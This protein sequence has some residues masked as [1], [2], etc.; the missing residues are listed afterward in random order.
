[1]TYC[2]CGNSY[3]TKRR[4][5]YYSLTCV[6]C[7]VKPVEFTKITFSVCKCGMILCNKPKTF[8]HCSA[9]EY[10]KVAF[11]KVCNI[12]I[13][14]HKGYCSRKCLKYS[15]RAREKKRVRDCTPKWA[16]KY[17][18]AKFHL[19]KNGNHV[20]HI[21]PINHPS[22]C[23]LNVLCNLQYLSPTENEFKSNKFDFT[24]ENK[25]WKLDLL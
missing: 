12:R 15:L 2:K 4:D 19:G 3:P 24:Y 22:V 16:N 13:P 23:G 21:I 9:Y 8:I 7:K 25:S 18:I 10:T 5:N 20:D 1:M 11:C 6:E 17:R 14:S